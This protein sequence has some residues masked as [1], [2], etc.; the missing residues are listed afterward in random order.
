MEQNKQ[1]LIF[2]IGDNE[3]SV[4]FAASIIHYLDK[5]YSRVFSL[6]VNLHS[7]EKFVM[8][9]VSEVEFDSLYQV[10]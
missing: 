2:F 4:K 9:A 5:N 7:E 1:Q 3:N 6:K 8:A 10:G